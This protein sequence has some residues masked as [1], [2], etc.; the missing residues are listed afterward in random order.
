M[1]SYYWTFGVII[2][3][4]CIIIIIIIMLVT[5]IDAIAIITIISISSRMV[6]ILIILRE[7]VANSRDPKTLA[8]GLDG[9]WV[10]AP[11]TVSGE[12]GDEVQKR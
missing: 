2:S 6:I 11:D 9:V 10:A 7:S 4:I 1:E 8:R 3:I 12:S 5:I